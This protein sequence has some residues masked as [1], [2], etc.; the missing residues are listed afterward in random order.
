MKIIGICGSAREKSY[1][2]MAMR[3]VGTMLPADVTLEFARIDDFPMYNQDLQDKGFPA[4]VERVAEQVRAA[5]AVLFGTPEHNWS[6]P[7]LLKNGIDW[8]ARVKNQPFAGKPMAV[9]GATIGTFGTARSQLHLRDIMIP[10]DGRMMN[11]PPVMIPQAQNKFD[12][13]GKVSDQLTVD[14]LKAFATAL[15]DWAKK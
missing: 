13:E 3:L 2:A 12:A 9:L 5:N 11:R 8:V 14:T 7:A 6:I 1:N 4:A 15:A 10:L